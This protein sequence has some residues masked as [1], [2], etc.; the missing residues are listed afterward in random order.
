[1]L[2]RF[3]EVIERES[4]EWATTVM[5]RLL[6]ICNGQVPFV[7]RLKV[8]AEKTPALNDWLSHAQSRAV[9]LVI[10]HLCTSNRHREDTLPLMPLAIERNDQLILLPDPETLIMSGDK[11]LFAGTRSA[12]N[13]Q[14]N[15]A[16]N[17]NALEYVILGH[18]ATGSLLGRL[19][20]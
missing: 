1:M 18:S 8:G 14:K 2:G 15:S 17:I 16:L 3:I 9:P 4:R 6:P 10:G 11:I 12:W 5:E 7:W 19:L 20:S 13:E